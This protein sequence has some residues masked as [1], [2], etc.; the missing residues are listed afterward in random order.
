METTDQNITI[1]TTYFYHLPWSWKMPWNTPTYLPLVPYHAYCA[2]KCNCHSGAAWCTFRSACMT[3]YKS[4][5]SYGPCS[6]QDITT[7]STC[8][9]SHNTSSILI[10]TYKPKTK[11]FSDEF[12][13]NCILS[14][15]PSV[16][17]SK[18][19]VQQIFFMNTVVHQ[20]AGLN[21]FVHTKPVFH[22]TIWRV[23]R[24]IWIQNII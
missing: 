14:F 15:I 23:N 12:G 3:A 10:N 9:V 21:C 16:V 18:Q 17:K 5:D 19:F 22:K 4:H 11:G 24:H 13:R 6:P 2:I 8:C 20:E 1:P 7:V